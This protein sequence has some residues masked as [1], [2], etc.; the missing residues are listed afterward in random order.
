MAAVQAVRPRPS[1]PDLRRPGP[2]EWSQVSLIGSA[3]RPAC[4][5]AVRAGAALPPAPGLRVLSPRQRVPRALALPWSTVPWS[6]HPRGLGRPSESL[7]PSHTLPSPLAQRVP[8]RVAARS[9]CCARPARGNG[10]R[11]QARPARS[12]P[13][14]WFGMGGESP[15]TASPA[16]TADGDDGTR[17]VAGLCCGLLHGLHPFAVGRKRATS[18]ASEDQSQV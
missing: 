1:S 5:P 2:S 4:P 3:C 6:V 7:T 18:V 14:E 12:K 16:E 15:R 17:S 8:R 10:A 11:R 9:A 13:G